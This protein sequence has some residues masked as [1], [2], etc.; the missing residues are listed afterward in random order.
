MATDSAYKTAL[1]MYA[2][3]KAAL[4]HRTRQDDAPD[5]SHEPAITVEENEAPGTWNRQ[6][7]EGTVKA[8][9]ALFRQTPAIDNSEV[10]LNAQT[11]L[12]RYVNSEGTSYTRQKSFA[13][14]QVNVDTQ[15]VDGMPL[16]D[17]DLACA[18]SIAELPSRDEMTR[19]IRTLAARIDAMRK[20]PLLEKYSGP[21]IFEGQAAAELFFQALGGAMVGVPR[22]VVD[23]LRLDG[24]YNNNG[25]LASKIGSRILPDA[26]SLKDA[27]AAREFHGQPLFGGY[28]VDDDGVKAGETELI[29]KGVLKTLLHTRALIPDTTHSTASRRGS[30]AMPSNLLFAVD[31]AMTPEQLKAELIKQ[32]KQRNKE[33][34]VVV[35]RIGNPTLAISLGR[36]RIIIFSSSNG[37][38]SIA[39]EPVLEA[40]KVFPDGHEEL[41]RNLT[42]DGLTQGDFR[43]ILAMSEP[44]SVYTAPIRIIQRAPLAAIGFLQPGGPNMISAAV[45]SMLFEDMSLKRPTGDIPNLPFSTHPFFEK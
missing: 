15:A 3:K 10:R 4:E 34:G 18:R 43:N 44:A 26:L 35:R 39:V 27:P 37:P 31:K 13:T 41:V 42:I 5:F 12:T 19:R 22:T 45:P 40:Y 14:L 33:F 23:D 8:L 32:V 36:S 30:G 25:G 1:D 7:I 16:A 29:D 17:F 38:S 2:K 6:E 20:A 21:V 11:W 28:Q 9:S 24:L